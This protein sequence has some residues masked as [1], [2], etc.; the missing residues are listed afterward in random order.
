MQEFDVNGNGSL[1][2]LEFEEFTRKMG[3]FLSTQELRVVFEAFD[4]NCDG[5]ISFAEMLETLRVSNGLNSN[6]QNQVSP[7][8]VSVVKQAWQ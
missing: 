1:D 7:D 5:Q 2:K 8:R 4:L 6:L 3:V